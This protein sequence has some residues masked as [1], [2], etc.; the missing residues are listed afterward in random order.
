MREQAF[1]RAVASTASCVITGCDAKATD[2]RATGCAAGCAVAGGIT[3][4]R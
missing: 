1:T 3:T 2:S 4:T